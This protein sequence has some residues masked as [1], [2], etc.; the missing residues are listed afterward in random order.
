MRQVVVGQTLADDFNCL[1]LMVWFRVAIP[2]NVTR[3]GRQAQYAKDQATYTPTAPGDYVGTYA[4]EVTDFHSGLYREMPPIS[5]PLDPTWSQAQVEGI[6]VDL[7]NDRTA[8]LTAFDDN[9]FGFLGSNYAGG[10]WTITK[11]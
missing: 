6:L 5:L 2:D 7:L 11:A 3:P 9:R 10:T 4:Q 8:K 1:A